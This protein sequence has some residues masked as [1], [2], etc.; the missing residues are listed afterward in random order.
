MRVDAGASAAKAATRARGATLLHVY[1]VVFWD[2]RSISFVSTLL[3]PF[4]SVP[5]DNQNKR[6]HFITSL[7][8]ISFRGFLAKEGQNPPRYSPTC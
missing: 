6:S 7:S 1:M 2:F 8:K 4:A 3:N 5:K